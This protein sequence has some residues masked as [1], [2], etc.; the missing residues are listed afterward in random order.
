MIDKKAKTKWEK[1]EISFSNYQSYIKQ[2]TNKFYLTLIDLLYISN[3]KGGNA[4]INESEKLIN[5]KLKSYSKILQEIDNKFSSKSLCSI[6]SVELKELNILIE[7]ICYLTNKDS[8]VRIDGFSVSYLSALLNAYFTNLIPILDRRILIN[9]NIVSDNDI[10]TQG[11]IKNIF[12]FY[13][14]LIH[15][16]RELSVNNKKSIRD[17][18]KEYFIKKINKITNK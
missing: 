13:E 2:K 6:N 14:I 3:F 4:T 5:K 7:N 11:Q 10:T 8:K 17:L 16:I 9:M 15:R 1:S 18:D 12:N